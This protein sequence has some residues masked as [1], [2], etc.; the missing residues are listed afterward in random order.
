MQ[1]IH[2]QGDEG[3]RALFAKATL[4]DMNRLEETVK[5]LIERKFKELDAKI[6]EFKKDQRDFVDSMITSKLENHL[7]KIQED[8]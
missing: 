5:D 2:D 4:N 1:S 8:R 3:L 7:K 6:E